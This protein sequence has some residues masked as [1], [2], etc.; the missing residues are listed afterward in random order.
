MSN[1][2]GALNFLFLYGLRYIRKLII[3]MGNEVFP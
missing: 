2:A 3:L 1:I